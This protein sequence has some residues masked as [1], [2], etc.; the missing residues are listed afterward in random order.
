MLALSQEPL[1]WM[2]ALCLVVL[3]LMGV[4]LMLLLLASVALSQKIAF[5]PWHNPRPGGELTQYW[6]PLAWSSCTYD[7]MRSLSLPFEEVTFRNRFGRTLR[8]WWVPGD[9]AAS[10]SDVRVGVVC[11]HGGGRDRRAFLRQSV[12][13]H[14]RGWHTLLFD[15]TNHGT[16]DGCKAWPWGRWP[17][18]ALTYGTREWVDVADAVQFTR[19]RLVRIDG[20]NAAEADATSL[21]AAPSPTMKVVLMGT[22]QGAV[23]CILAAAHER[24]ST[25]QADDRERRPALLA[26]AFVAENAFLSPAHL[27]WHLSGHVAQ[28]IFIGPQRYAAQLGMVRA[29]MLLTTALALFRT[30]NL[31]VTAELLLRTHKRLCAFRWLLRRCVPER[32]GAAQSFSGF[33][34]AVDAVSHIGCPVLFLHG[35]RD[36]IVPYQHSL[37]LFQLAKQPRQ[38]WI[39]ES[40]GHTLL[41]HTEP[42]VFERQVCGFIEEYVVDR[43]MSDTAPHPP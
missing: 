42:E 36:I 22:S 43:S 12:L 38:L 31:G 2:R 27:F 16:S 13:F 20:G 21:N 7:P 32:H 28:R 4:W 33:A 9:P 24:L 34:S 19:I 29:W 5:P 25:P 23:S 11:V 30:G 10:A 41:Y 14:R 18:R 40:A 37:Q 1:Q 6:M 17:G 8:G 26:D 39:S 3:V 35:K 15:C